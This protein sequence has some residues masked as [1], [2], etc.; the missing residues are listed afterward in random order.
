MSKQS[1]IFVCRNCGNE[2]SKWFGKCPVCNEWNTCYEEKLNTKLNNKSV[3]KNE[4]A[5]IAL[6]NVKSQDIIRT[7]TG[8]EELDRVLGGGL[9]KGSLTLLRR[10]TRNS[11][12][13]P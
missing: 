13:L 8:F 5:P 1:T 3:Q 2:S 6:N 11:E 4:I 9:V 12:N 10:R 7:C